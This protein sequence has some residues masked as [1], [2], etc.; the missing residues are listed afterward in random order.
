MYLPLVQRILNSTIDTNTNICPSEIIFGNQLPIM[1]PLLADNNNTILSTTS[2]HDYIRQIS[3]AMSV[4]VTRS[5]NYLNSISK[6][7][8]IDIS[9]GHQFNV[10]DYVLLTYPSQ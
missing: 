8:D 3:D 2:V 6:H 9:Q 10:G 5:R 1:S 7:Q 4:L